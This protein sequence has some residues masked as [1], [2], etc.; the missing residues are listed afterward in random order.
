MQAFSPKPLSL[1]SI[2][3]IGIGRGCVGECIGLPLRKVYRCPYIGIDIWEYRYIDS[4]PIRYA[5]YI[6]KV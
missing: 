3:G 4:V 5:I 1:V 6:F 2:P